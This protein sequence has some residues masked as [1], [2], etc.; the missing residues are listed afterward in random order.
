[1]WIVP[2]ELWERIEPLLLAVPRRAGQRT[3]RRLDHR[4]VLSRIMFV[5]N[6]GIRWEFLPQELGFGFDMTCWRLRDCHKAECGS[7]RTSRWWPSCMPPA[8]STG[9][10]L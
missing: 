9:P 1:M 7:G 10:V 3:H 5:V 6:T 4:K 8:H 2:D